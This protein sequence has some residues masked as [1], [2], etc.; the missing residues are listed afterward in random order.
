M[1][2][3][4]L[5][6][7]HFDSNPLFSL[8]FLW[9]QASGFQERSRSNPTMLTCLVMSPSMASRHPACLFHPFLPPSLMYSFCNFRLLAHQIWLQLL[10]TVITSC[11]QVQWQGRRGKMVSRVVGGRTMKSTLVECRDLQR[12]NCLRAVTFPRRF[13]TRGG[14]PNVRLSFAVGVL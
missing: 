4:P 9:T 5:I 10:G 2:A 12:C 8:P 7:D 11:V 14:C 6:N 3:D 1:T 13:G